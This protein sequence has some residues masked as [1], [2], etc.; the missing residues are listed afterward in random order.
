[1]ISLHGQRMSATT[2]LEEA[3]TDTVIVRLRC[4]PRWNC[5]RRATNA[6]CGSMAKRERVINY[7]LFMSGVEKMRL[8]NLDSS[9]SA[10]WQER[11][12]YR[13]PASHSHGLV[14]YDL[15]SPSPKSVEGW[16]EIFY[17]SDRYQQIDFHYMPTHCLCIFFLCSPFIL[18]RGSWILKFDV[19]QPRIMLLMG[20]FCVIASPKQKTGWN[21]QR[22]LFQYNCYFNFCL[23]VVIAEWGGINKPGF[24]N[25][26]KFTIFQILL[27]FITEVKHRKPIW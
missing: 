3:S 20:L 1:M 15:F 13:T 2:K 12:A 4:K 26:T 24:L 17:V 23:C 27:C 5:F 16:N 18:W 10:V 19:S 22:A 7:D 8:H 21:P 14:I 11:D 9:L 6:L 25:K